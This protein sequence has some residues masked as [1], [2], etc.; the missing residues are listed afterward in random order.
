MDKGMRRIQSIHFVGIGGVGMGGIAEVLLTQ[1]YQVTG[2]DKNANAITNRLG[3]LGATIY[4]KHAPE[5]VDGA[6]VI[7]VSSAI[8]PDN[9]EVQAGKERRIPIV[10]RAA[11]LAELMRFRYGIAV[12]G[13][14]GKTTTTSLTAS[15]LAQGGLD[16]TFVIGGRLNSAGTNAR[17]GASRYLV[18]EADESDASFLHLHPMVAVVTNVDEDHLSTYQN[19]FS[20]LKETFLQFLHHLPFYGYAVM[21]LDCPVVAEL[22]PEVARPVLTYGFDEKSDYRAVDYRQAGLISHF[23]VKRPRHP[24]LQIALNLPGKHNVQNTLAAI[25]IATEE[26]VE[27]TAIQEA[28]SEFA[29]IDR[30]FNVHGLYNQKENVTIIE[31]YGHHP[32]ELQATIETAR[33]TWPNRRCVMAFQPHRY[34]RT[35]QLFDDF[36]RAL[37]EVDVLLLFE[38]YA[39]GE[40]PIPNADSRA[41]CRSIRQR[42][43]V[44]P[45]H[46]HSFEEFES[47]L[48][49]ILEPNDVLLLQ[50]AGNVG[51]LAARLVDA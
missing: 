8:R 46:V 14:H 6:D 5:N 41:L 39:A 25:V 43:G 49:N 32:K 36:S 45:I 30:R 29:G 23:T 33:A 35:S 44:D 2:S 48:P 12:A 26:G 28:L 11:M 16:P 21:C 13:T 10:P 15:V 18:A 19:D 31:D 9:I 34:S 27:D 20:K 40:E 7:V 47:I 22:L 38:V 17:L 24:D 3:D 50:G 37:S 42:G 51:T 4:F 1:G